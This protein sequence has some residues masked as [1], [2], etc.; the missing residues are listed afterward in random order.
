[1]LI[2]AHMA[3]IVVLKLFWKPTVSLTESLRA[4]HDAS[5][6]SKHPHYAHETK[7]QKVQHFLNQQV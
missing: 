7:R 5:P 3:I 1:M 2:N 4:V 6:H